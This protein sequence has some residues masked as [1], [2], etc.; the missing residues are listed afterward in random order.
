MIQGP[1]GQYMVL[2]GH[3]ASHTSGRNLSVKDSS[4]VQVQAAEEVS[5]KRCRFK[6]CAKLFVL[7]NYIHICFGAN[8]GRNK[9]Y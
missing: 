9:C 2:S 1:V 3:K 4:V 6:K 8:Q 5:M 7:G